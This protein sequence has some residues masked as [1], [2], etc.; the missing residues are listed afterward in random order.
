MFRYLLNTFGQ[1]KQAPEQTIQIHSHRR[2]TAADVPEE[3]LPEFNTW[4]YPTAPSSWIV[5]TPQ[6]P[7]R[8][9]CWAVEIMD[10]RLCF[11]D[12]DEDTI[13]ELAPGEW[14][15]IR[16]ERLMQEQVAVEDAA[17]EMD[18]LAPGAEHYPQEAVL[19]EQELRLVA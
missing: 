1:L 10:Q 18:D 2:M 12:A 11:L 13:L 19:P 8:A 6:G 17:E 14:R 15:S 3:I 5:N 4:D 7:Y 9:I 16:H